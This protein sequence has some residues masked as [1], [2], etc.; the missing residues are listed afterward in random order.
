[1]CDLFC[2]RLG[3]CPPSLPFVLPTALTFWRVCLVEFPTLDSSYCFLVADDK[4]LRVGSGPCLAF[5][6][7]RCSQ[8]FVPAAPLAGEARL[9][10]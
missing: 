10:E 5:L 1:M 2:S 7:Q 6:P 8:S 9:S 3:Q 4:A